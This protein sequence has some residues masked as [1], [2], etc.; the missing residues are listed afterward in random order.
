[1]L[2][3]LGIL[4]ACIINN[5]PMFIYVILDTAGQEEFGYVTS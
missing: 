4:I 3:I 1:M 5:F 2:D